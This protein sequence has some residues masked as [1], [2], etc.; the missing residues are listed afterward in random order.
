MRNIFITA[1]LLVVALCLGAENAPI[2]ATPKKAVSNR[3]ESVLRSACKFLQDSPCFSLKA[4]LW[5]EHLSENSQKVQFGKCMEMEIKRPNLLRADILHGNGSGRTFW[6]NGKELV[7]H[8]KARNLYSRS[9]MPNTIEKM[10]DASCEQG[11]DLPLAD[12]VSDD[13]YGTLTSGVETARYYGI[14]S[15]LGKPCHH[16]AFTQKNIDW[17]IWIEDGARPLIRK[18]VII[19]KNEEAQPE[20]TALITDWNMTDRISEGFFQFIKPTGAIEI[21][22]LKEG[23]KK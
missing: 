6:Y 23:A 22:S 3:A 13:P 10:L 17:Q 18:F 14:E 11:I 12:L 19:H 5:H 16:L 1:A 21:Q 15:V 8:D 9:S 7:I 20:F 4:E 2:P